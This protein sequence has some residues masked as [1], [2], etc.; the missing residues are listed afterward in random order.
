[1]PVGIPGIGIGGLF[2]V[3][4]ALLMVVLELY[5]TIRGKSSL[6]RWR[7]VGRQAAIA[8]CIILLTVFALWILHLTV[9]GSAY[10]DIRVGNAQG[11]GAG[12]G[13]GGPLVAALITILESAWP[14]LGTLV[15]LTLLL[16][17]AK[18]LPWV[19]GRPQSLPGSLRLGESLPPQKQ[20]AVL[21]SAYLDIRVGDAQGTGAGAGRGTAGSNFRAYLM[22]SAALL[23]FAVAA[24]AITLILV[25]DNHPEVSQV[26]EPAAFHLAPPGGGEVE[27]AL[28]TQQED[29]QRGADDE[30]NSRRPREN[31]GSEGRDVVD[32]GAG[33]AG[34]PGQGQNTPLRAQNS[35]DAATA[36]SAP[37]ASEESPVATKPDAAPTPPTARH[38]PQEPIHE[39]RG[40]GAIE[41]APEPAPAPAPAPEPV[42]TDSIGS[43]YYKAPIDP[44]GGTDPVPVPAAEPAP[45]A[46]PAPEPVPTDPVPTDRSPLPRTALGLWPYAHAHTRGMPR[47]RPYS[48]K[49]V[50]V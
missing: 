6:A 1:M 46:A 49:L 10:L 31:T 4:S 5:R 8:A 26:R 28:Q 43:T 27:L 16:C 2:Y 45:T 9:P 13:S 19:A 33:R 30:S 7:V 38:R 47:L 11:I 36:L 37:I 32:D 21:G 35:R 42:P 34:Q 25:R 39:V 24:V 22:G 15:F 48:P 40:E 50:E 12:A 14:I 23:V 41:P 20:R 17:L 18:A 44:V 29:D 3:I